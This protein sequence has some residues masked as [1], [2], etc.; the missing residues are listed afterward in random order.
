LGQ[1]K[2]QILGRDSKRSQVIKP[3]W[4]GRQAAHPQK[5]PQE[6]DP[7]HY[8][9]SDVSVFSPHQSFLEFLKTHGNRI[10]VL[11]LKRIKKDVAS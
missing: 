11:N 1:D 5:G 3:E 8:K 4:L 10:I 2:P 6:K 9:N 7:E